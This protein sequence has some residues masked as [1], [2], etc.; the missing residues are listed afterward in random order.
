VLQYGG[1]KE[2]EYSKMQPM[3]KEE[4]KKKESGGF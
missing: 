1:E 3:K 2:W 4:Q